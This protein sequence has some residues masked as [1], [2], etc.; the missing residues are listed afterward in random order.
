MGQT[1]LGN[2]VHIPFLFL[3]SFYLTQ[4]L[5]DR[6]R[7]ASPTAALWRYRQGVVEDLKSAW[8][9]WI[10]G[11]AIFFSVPLFLRLPTNHAMSFGYVCVLS[12]MRGRP[13]GCVAESG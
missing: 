7:S 4:E 11:H 6:G 5:V 2:F 3:P 10:P 9:I 8:A 12:L 13:S 1:A